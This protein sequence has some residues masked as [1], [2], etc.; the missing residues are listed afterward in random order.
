[1]A[2]VKIIDPKARRR[3]RRKYSQRKRISGTAE[4]PRLSVFRSNS[5]IYAQAIDD[6]NQVTLAAASDLDASLKSGVD[7]KDK[8]AVAK[9]VG[10]LVGQKLKQKD[11]N[12]VV[13]DRNGFNYHGRVKALADGARE[14]G[15]EF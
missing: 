9:L 8:S 6:V 1:M 2:H 11:V 15:L 10:E 12:T 13:F 5:H 4:R 3:Q 7:G 14:A